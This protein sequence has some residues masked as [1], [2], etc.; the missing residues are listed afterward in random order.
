[1]T[2]RPLM[3]LHRIAK[4]LRD[5]HLLVEVRGSEDVA[6]SGASQDSRTV[7]PGDLFL[8]WAGVDHDAHDFAPQ[9][10]AAGA[11]ALMVERPLPELELPQLIVTNGRAGAA[12]VSQLIAGSPADRLE[13]IGITG[14]NGKTTT[15]AITRHLLS[16]QG[17]TASLGTLGLVDAAGE[18]RP[19]TVGLTTPGPVEFASWLRELADDGAGRVVLEAS[20]HALDQHRLD[21]VSFAVATFT[22]LS[23]DHLDYHPDMA[24]Y[25]SAKLRLADLL[26]ADGVAVVNADDPAWDGVTGPG[27]TVRFGIE[28]GSAAGEEDAQ[29]D[30]TAREIQ[31][32]ATGTRFQLTWLDRFGDGGADG[33]GHGA[34]PQTRAVRLPLVGG[35]NVENALAAAGIALALGATLDAVV[36]G[37]ESV[38]PV[39]GRLQVVLDQPIGVIIDFAHT[40][41]ALERVLATLRPLT[42]ARLIVLFGAGGDRDRT[43]RAPMAEAVAR[44][45]DLI[46]LTSD[47][48]RT[49]DPD[50]ILDDLA[51]G[52][53]EAH[54][55]REV[56][57]RAAIRWAVES[58]EP[59]DLVLLAGKGHEQYQVLGTEKHPFDEAAIAREAWVARGAA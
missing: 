4:V 29:P 35:F 9:A 18:P 31:A 30:L 57:R 11:V 17:A 28:G 7:A 38:P 39:P 34:A 54:F 1:V 37:L 16:A 53:S 25:R 26:R 8:A 44:W 27:R 22:N 23:R 13:L 5:A 56:D 48:P 55:H 43:K 10:A 42:A 20:S 32:E 45:A 41:D 14:T 6:V 2:S 3:T 47:N 40:P 33:R 58:A 24:A 12:R 50:R 15:A 46:V 21:G 36:G 59:G 19:G 52:L 49:E 51:E